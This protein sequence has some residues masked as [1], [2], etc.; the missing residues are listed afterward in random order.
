MA[1]KKIGIEDRGDKKD[2][3]RV[4]VK[5]VGQAGQSYRPFYATITNL[6]LNGAT[7]NLFG[8]FEKNG[9]DRRVEVSELIFQKKEDLDEFVYFDLSRLSASRR[10]VTLLSDALL[11][12]GQKDEYFDDGLRQKVTKYYISHPSIKIDPARFVR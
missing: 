4:L 7:V 9:S 12:E 5:Y 1:K 2:R 11:S 6:K 3:I 10:E 8:R